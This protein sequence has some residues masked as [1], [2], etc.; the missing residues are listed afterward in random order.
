[1]VVVQCR[2][3]VF[4]LNVLQKNAKDFIDDS[5][6]PVVKERE[7]SVIILHQQLGN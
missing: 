5:P 4:T 2:L 1:M 3:E 7:G 6:G